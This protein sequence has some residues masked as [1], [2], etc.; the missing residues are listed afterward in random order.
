MGTGLIVGLGVGAQIVLSV[1]NMYD[2]KGKRMIA[3]LFLLA[4]IGAAVL[5]PKVLDEVKAE[6]PGGQGEKVEKVRS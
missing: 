5:A 4:G 3:S 6:K 2:K 1:F